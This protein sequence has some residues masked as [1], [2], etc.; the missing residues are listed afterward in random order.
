MALKKLGGGCLV[1]GF[2]VFGFGFS[3]ITIVFALAFA[4]CAVAFA[5]CA[6]A[7]ACPFA[8]CAVAFACS[9][10]IALACTSRCALAGTAFAGCAVVFAGR[11]VA[12]G[13]T[14]EHGRRLS[15]AGGRTNNVHDL[16]AVAVVLWLVVSMASS[17][18]GVATAALELQMATTCTCVC[19]CVCSGKKKDFPNRCGYKRRSGN[20]RIS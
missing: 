4:G 14:N 5:G 10:G 11:A 1:I 20:K 16:R 7:F 13:R 2:F 19:L 12:G 15:R 8:G 9:L 17:V 6:M 3:C 18:A